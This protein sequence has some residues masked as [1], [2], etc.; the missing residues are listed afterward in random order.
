MKITSDLSGI[1]KFVQDVRDELKQKMIDIAHEGVQQA[2]DKG[3]IKIILT[4]SAVLRVLRVVLDG[5]IEDMYVPA[6]TGH[7]EAK[8]KTE[9]LCFYSNRPQNGIMLADGMEYAS[10]VESK[11]FDVISKPAISIKNNA[12]KEFSK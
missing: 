1:D 4:T 2:K 9:N 12:E 6:E 10:F 7:N 8:V 11:G 3:N 5:K